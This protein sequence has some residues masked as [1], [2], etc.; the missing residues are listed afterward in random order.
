[1]KLSYHPAIQRDVSEVWRHYRNEAGDALAE[2]FWQ[3]LM[4]RLNEV[5]E[6]PERFSPYRGHPRFQRAG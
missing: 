2:R 6:H 1:M 3:E 5:A 4:A